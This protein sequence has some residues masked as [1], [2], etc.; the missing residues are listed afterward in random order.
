MTTVLCMLLFL[1]YYPKQSTFAADWLPHLETDPVYLKSITRTALRFLSYH[2]K[3]SE[4]Q[5][6]GDMH[7]RLPNLTEKSGH[8]TLQR[9]RDSKCELPLQWFRDS[10]CVRHLYD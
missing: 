4:I 2:F 1:V 5:N 7:T 6:G 8:R 10:K 9:F 3:G